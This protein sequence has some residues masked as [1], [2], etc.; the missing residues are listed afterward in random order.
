MQDAVTYGAAQERDRL[1]ALYGYQILDTPPERDFD[2]ITALA[3]Q[4]CDTPMSAISLVDSDR[5]WLKARIGL[6]ACETSRESSFCAHAMNGVDVLVVEDALIDPRF[7][8]NPAVVGEPHVRFYAGAPLVA[9]GGQRLGSLCVIDRRPR[10]ITANQ[11]E[12]LLILAR[13]VMVHLELRQYGRALAAANQRLLDAERVQDEFLARVTHELRTPLT[14]IHGYLEVLDEPDLPAGT[15]TRFLRRIRR[16]SDRLLA[17]VD[18]MLLA[19]QFSSGAVNLERRA[20]DLAALAHSA[21]SQNRPLAESKG[22]TITAESAGP[23]PAHADPV[24]LAQALDRLILNAVKFTNRGH[25][26]IRATAQGERAVLEVRDTGIG[27]PAEERARLF[28]PFRRA[29]AAERAEVQGVGLGLNIVKAIV[30]GHGGTV[31]LDSETGRGTTVTIT[32]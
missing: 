8:T 31:T 13:H 20:V 1:D 3:A 28:T 10:R 24:R 18:D 25:V 23:V 26:A 7:A 9:A 30:D 15:A 22:L 12:G 5:Q 14:S 32:L 16:N 27:I 29:S 11:R 6:S 2:D 4:L 19:A 17:L 21:A